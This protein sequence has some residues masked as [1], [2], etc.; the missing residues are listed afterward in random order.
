MSSLYIC[1]GCRRH[2]FEHET[3]CPFCG[4][5]RTRGPSTGPSALARGG[6][7]AAVLVAGMTGL[8]ACPEP[9]QEEKKL[10]PKETRITTK[11]S[12]TTEPAPTPSPRPTD[13]GMN[14]VPAYGAPPMPLP[15]ADASPS[16]DAG[17]SDATT[18]AARDVGAADAKPAPVPPPPPPPPPPPIPKPAYGVPFKGDP[19][20]F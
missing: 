7:V 18:D 2:I 13:L 17:T 19:S 20:H 10:D 3:A 12:D 9:G 15:M 5:S 11:P 1:T 4:A 8:V 14:N 16:S 6:V